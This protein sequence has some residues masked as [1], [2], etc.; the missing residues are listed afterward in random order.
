M[1][2]ATEAWA[3]VVRDMLEC[4]PFKKRAGVLKLAA[5]WHDEEVRRGVQILTSKQFVEMDDPGMRHWHDVQK[6][7][8]AVIERFTR[9]IISEET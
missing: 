8:G 3:V 4:V 2:D 5:E 6:H 7:K 9:Y 1:D